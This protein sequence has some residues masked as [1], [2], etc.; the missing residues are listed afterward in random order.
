MKYGKWKKASEGDQTAERG[1][2][3]MSKG[4]KTPAKRERKLSETVCQE[5]SKRTNE[6]VDK[7]GRKRGNDRKR[8]SV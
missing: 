7:G 4:E 2:K 5:Q 1:N 8:V 6:C 3:R